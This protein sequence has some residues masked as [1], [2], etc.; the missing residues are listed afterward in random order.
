M[1]EAKLADK[2][3]L[4]GIGINPT[5]YDEA[6]AAV[7]EAA[8]ARR[9]FA[10]SAL[11]THGLMYGVLYPEFAEV[12]DR[13]D[14]VTPDGQPVRWAM[15]ILLETRLQDR[16][17]GP[18]LTEHVCA[19]AERE[20]LS[21]YLFG[22]TEETC[23]QLVEAL[24]RRFPK[25]SVAGI[26]PDRF[27][28]ASPEEDGGDVER[29]IRSGAH[30]VLVGRGCPRQERWV[31]AHRAL[32]PAAMLAVGAAFDYLAGTLRPPP[33]WMQQVGLEW[34]YRLYQEPRR[35]WRRYLVTNTY[36]TVHF[37]RAW[38]RKGWHELRAR[39]ERRRAD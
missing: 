33:V 24:G 20:Q 4:F 3:P 19:A 38:G 8:V 37:L 34:L 9:S 35:L 6:T 21:V 28:E 30:I 32:I 16:V 17:Y 2:V 13:I 29:I 10:V 12:L 11:A 26:Q 7:I 5:S 36:F 39:L 23:R 18:Q 31:A 1:T 27:R 14:L 15:N 25:L 22:S